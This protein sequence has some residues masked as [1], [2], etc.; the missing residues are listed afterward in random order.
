MQW[1]GYSLTNGAQIWGPTPSQ[2]AFDYY[3]TPGSPP[4]QA[5]LAYGTLYSSSY[6]GICYAYNDQTGKLI[7]T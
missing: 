4:L 7:F 2:A 1:V 3:G 6:S 5:F